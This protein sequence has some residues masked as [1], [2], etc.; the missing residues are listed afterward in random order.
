MPSAHNALVLFPPT[1]RGYHGYLFPLLSPTLP[2]ALSAYVY[3]G[4][5]N[6]RT[7]NKEPFL[8][9]RY[10]PFFLFMTVNAI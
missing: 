3:F 2:S 6:A 5:E 7:Y 9:Y 4:V 10:W 1:S 8:D